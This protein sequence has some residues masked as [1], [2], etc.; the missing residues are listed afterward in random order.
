MSDADPTH[1]PAGGAHDDHGSGHGAHEPS[2]PLGPID[3]AAW[4]Y[5]IAGGAV[6]VVV[7]LALYVAGGA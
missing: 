3:V 4:G 5:A 2:E 1:A 7:A 6:G